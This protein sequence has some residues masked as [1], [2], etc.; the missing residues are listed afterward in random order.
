MQKEVQCKQFRE[1]LK[2]K[3]EELQ[4]LTSSFT[5]E[6]M[7]TVQDKQSKENEDQVEE[8]DEKKM[9]EAASDVLQERVAELESRLRE[10]NEAHQHELVALQESFAASRAATAAAAAAA[11]T[12]G[13]GGAAGG[14]DFGKVFQPRCETT[15]ELMQVRRYP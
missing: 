6:D 4:M 14:T 5:P 3:E 2:E 10:V 9:P 7:K 1:L 12:G 11:G 15:L 13:G 8:E